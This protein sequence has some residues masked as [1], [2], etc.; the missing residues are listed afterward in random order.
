MGGYL[1]FMRGYHH[2][3]GVTT[4]KRTMK[5]RRGSPW[6]ATPLGGYPLPLL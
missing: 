2:E 1:M 3:E 5:R 6:P 4:M